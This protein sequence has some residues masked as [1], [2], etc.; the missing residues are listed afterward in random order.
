MIALLG[1]GRRSWTKIS[2]RPGQ[3]QT[4]RKYLGRRRRRRDCLRGIAQIIGDVSKVEEKICAL[5]DSTFTSF[6]ATPM[7]APVCVL[8]ESALTF[9][10]R[11]F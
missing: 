3:G 4:K 2:A 5:L 1:V 7:A 11:N 8:P 6:F 9:P 10:R